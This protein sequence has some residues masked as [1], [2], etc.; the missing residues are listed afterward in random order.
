[1]RL[2][3]SS[4][5]NHPDRGGDTEVAKVLNEA[6]DILSD[7]LRRAEY[8]LEL[9]RAEDRKGSHTRFE[10]APTD[11]PFTEEPPS[12]SDES[13]G[14]NRVEIRLRPTEPIRFARAGRVLG[15]AVI[16]AW[17]SLSHS[18]RVLWIPVAV[19]V[20]IVLAVFD[21]RRNATHRW[22]GGA[23]GLAAALELSVKQIDDVEFVVLLGMVA[24]VLKVI[25]LKVI[26]RWLR[27][28]VMQ[29]RGDS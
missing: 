7:S 3:A 6:H 23:I 18:P 28:H 20:A 13:A 25:R 29:A 2:G 4:S 15:Y 21:S 17:L 5:R 10:P 22:I 24:I 26:R 8:D 12:W 11:V 19:V 27:R 14:T 16:A 1:M 9:R